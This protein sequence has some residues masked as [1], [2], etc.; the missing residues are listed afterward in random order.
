M[1][2]RKSN[3]NGNT[4]LWFMIP[5]RERESTSSYLPAGD[6]WHE[7]EW[8]P[9]RSSVPK[10]TLVLLLEKEHSALITN[11]NQMKLTWLKKQL[12][13]RYNLY[14]DNLSSVSENFWSRKEKAETFVLPNIGKKVGKRKE[15]YVFHKIPKKPSTQTYR[16]RDWTK[17]IWSQTLSEFQEI[18]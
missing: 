11:R 16:W 7:P 8:D 9:L 10:L 17:I 5:W 6:S 1:P 15:R 14:Q 3:N 13:T 18:V 2:W 12:N 4:F